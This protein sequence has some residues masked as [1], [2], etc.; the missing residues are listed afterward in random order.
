[1]KASMGDPNNSRSFQE[2]WTQ[3]D[4]RLGFQWIDGTPLS[5]AP[6]ALTPESPQTQRPDVG[7]I[8][9]WVVDAATK[10]PVPNVSIRV[11]DPGRALVTDERGAFAIRDYPPGERPILLNSEY[12]EMGLVFITFRAGMIDTVRLSYTPNGVT[13]RYA[14]I[15]FPRQE[16]WYPSPSF[17]PREGERLH[18]RVH[19]GDG[20][21]IPRAYVVLLQGKSRFGGLAD[22]SGDMLFPIIPPGPGTLVIRSSRFEPFARKLDFRRSGSD[23]LDVRLTLA[24]H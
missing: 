22:D 18:V 2:W 12:Y 11:F 1:M 8:V 15:S 3:V 20:R 6:L 17:S 19:D 5:H 14:P 13:P 16:P 24:K 9:G 23:S 21:A 4:S 7:S 10:Q